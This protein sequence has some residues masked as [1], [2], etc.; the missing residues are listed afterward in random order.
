[1]AK[2]LDLIIKGNIITVVNQKPRAEAIGIKGEKIVS[3]GTMKEVEAD[4]GK[5]I[6]VLD[7]KG[8]TILPGFMDTHA[9]PMG[10]GRNRMGVDLSSVTSIAETLDKVR[11]RVKTTPEGKWVFCPAYNRLY[12]KEKRF[13]TIKE[14][15]DIS[16]KHLISI[17]HVDGH[18]SQLNSASL[19][20][21]KLE[22]GMP[23]V[24][25]G[26]DGKPTGLIEDPASGKTLEIIGALTTDEERLTA[27]KLVAE[28][29]V[30]V[31][32]T[33][34]FAKEPLETQEFI[35]K[36][37]KK[38]PVRIHPMVMGATR[39]V[40][41]LEKIMK[42]DFLGDH[43]CVATAADGSIEAHTAALF[44]PYTNAPETQGMLVFTDDELYNFVERSHK[45]GFQ[46]SIHAE[47]E[48]CIEQ[49]LW[50]YEKVLEK[51]PRKDH[52]HRIEHYEIPSI[53]QIKR[54]ARL[55]VIAAMQPAFIPYCEGLNL[56]YYRAILGEQ[57]LKRANAFRSI[58]DEGIIVSG[59]SDT[60]VTR[61]NPL[62]GI[63]YCV[64][65]PLIEQRT[66]IYEA[67]EMFTINGAK[68]GFEE[69]IKGSIE[70]GKLADFV[71]LSDDPYRV[72]RDKIKDI[73]VKM[74]IV[75]GRVVYK[76]G[77]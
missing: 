18:F 60:P 61:M 8:M 16:T 5:N 72:P 11:Q 62:L 20:F 29:A 7:L 33:T 39:G 28:E 46:I 34:L 49:V 43:V 63:H 27:L 73:K 66:D 19:E 3:V 21:L 47:S 58:L 30:S 38:I 14:L 74:T 2:N 69:D 55:G 35:T 41:V 68:T 26:P 31:G 54:T 42:A 6:E 71:V 25:T 48:R 12:V 76:N 65:H 59:G 24:V 1:M 10:Q 22:A 56:E 67:I 52:R 64:N 9:H 36:N 17:Q 77:L 70:A 51:Y 50:A 15:D 40:L 23:G 37:L 32:I 75:G 53:Q 13:P 44:E 45:A 57:R 4:T